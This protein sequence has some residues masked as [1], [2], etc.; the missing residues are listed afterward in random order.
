MQRTKVAVAAAGLGLAFGMAAAGPAGAQS[1]PSSATVRAIQTIRVVPNRYIQDGLRW[2]RDVYRIRSGGT[3]TVINGAAGEGPHT[4]SIVRRRDLPRTAGQIN[5]CR[6]CQVFERA[7]G[8]NPESNAPP[9][10][11]YVENG[12]GQNTPPNVDRPGDS[13]VTG[14]GRRGERI[15]LK[16]TARRGTTLNFM[17][18][19]HPWMQARLVVG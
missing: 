14:P 2:N 13:G 6:I 9:Q 4:L 15:R 11:Q 12:V 1:T 8:A 17:C 18:A 3:L 10:F 19:I 16:V 7:H 5:N